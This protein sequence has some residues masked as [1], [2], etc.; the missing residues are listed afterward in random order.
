MAPNKHD[1]GGGMASIWSLIINRLE[2]INILQNEKEADKDHG[3]QVVN[4]D[5]HTAWKLKAESIMKLKIK[6]ISFLL[7]HRIRGIWPLQ[8]V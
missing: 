3:F 2:P 1:G 4:N 6:M 5:P 8:S 7:S